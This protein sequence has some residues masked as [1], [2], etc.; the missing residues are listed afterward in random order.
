[1]ADP[2]VDNR[3]ASVKCICRI[4]FQVGFTVPRPVGVAGIAGHQR[5]IILGQHGGVSGIMVRTLL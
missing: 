2:D 1:M 5:L 4:Y 3:S